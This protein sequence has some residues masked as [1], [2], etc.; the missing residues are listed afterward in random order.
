MSTDANSH[1]RV[2]ID[3]GPLYGHRTG[4]GV[5]VDGM[6]TALAERS[7]I[8]LVPYL[9]SRRASPRPGHRRL[10]IAGIVASHLWSRSDRPTA[11][12][13]LTDVD[14]VHGTNYVAPPSRHPT[15]VSVYD[16]WF[17]RHPDQAT[18]LVRRA[19]DNLR[20]AVAR[21]AWLH[22]T[23]DAT[24]AEARALL[25]TDRVRTVHL[26]APPAPPTVTHTP[27]AVHDLAGRRL[28]VAVGTAERRKDLPLLVEAF[29]HVAH[30]HDDV[31]L[32]L[33]GA[34]GDDSERVAG[35]VAASPA[36]DR[37]RRLGPVD[38]P[39][40]AWL[41]RHATV[42]VYPSR[43]EGFGF[44]ILE[45]NAAGTPVVATAVGS[46]PE[47]AGDAAV[48]V[49]DPTRRPCALADAIAGVLDG[50]DRL[51]LI[52]AGYR[53]LRR[54]DWATT[55]EGL[56]ELYAAAMADAATPTGGSA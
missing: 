7:D 39:T 16:C 22:V 1:L 38:E 44:P 41:L 19:G 25:R 42:L 36:R 6:T 5:A 45:A 17:L 23:S 55:A 8:T 24:A 52:E 31:L 11:D 12:R 30:D 3:V 48:L 56:V 37:I 28:V 15:V 13:W 4:V 40:K 53:N 10:P 46:V 32:T 20:R 33:A 29:A 9:T 2:A 14:L 49:A 34:D 43:D 18:P 35:A 27:T 51:A 50:H 47:I 21:G 54:F 26:G